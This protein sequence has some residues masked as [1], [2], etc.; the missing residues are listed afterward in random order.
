VWMD[1]SGQSYKQFCIT[2]T[3]S[4]AIFEFHCQIL[5]AD[6]LEDVHEREDVLS[7]STGASLQILLA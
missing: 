7:E 1:P 4:I 3:I 5:T 2:K 6:Y